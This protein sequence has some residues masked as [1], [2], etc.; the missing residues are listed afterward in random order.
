MPN[1]DAL[2]QVFTN[3]SNILPDT[4]DLPYE[5]V[6]RR[7]ELRDNILHEL[8][9]VIQG[10]GGLSSNLRRYTIKIAE[11]MYVAGYHDGVADTNEFNNELLT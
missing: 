5:A 10:K 4:E 8:N 11:S 1:P 2:A 9:P 3:V 6:R 7:N